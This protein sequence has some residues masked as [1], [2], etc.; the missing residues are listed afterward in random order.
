MKKI[1]GTFHVVNP[2]TF[3]FETYGDE[4]GEFEFTARLLRIGVDDGTY[5]E[6]ITNLS[7]DE[8]PLKRITSLYKSR[9]FIERGYENLKYGV[10][11]QLIYARKMDL[12]K[13]EVYAGMTLHNF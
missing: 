12:V 3:D 11:I 9:W 10:E 6:L 5:E 4:N 8:Y 2:K 7:E 1:V 13:Q